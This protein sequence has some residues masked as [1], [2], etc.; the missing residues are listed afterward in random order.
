[1]LLYSQLANIVRTRG[2]E[3]IVSSQITYRT[4]LEQINSRASELCSKIDANAAVA[5]QTNRPIEFIVNF[6]A[7]NKLG[8]AVVPEN[9]EIPDEIKCAHVDFRLIGNVVEAQNRNES[10]KFKDVALIL[11]TSG[12]T[13]M[14][15]AVYLTNRNILS[16]CLTVGQ[17]C[18]KFRDRVCGLLSAP[19][20]YVLGSNMQMNLMLL[21]GG[22]IY[23]PESA[24]IDSMVDALQ[25]GTVNYIC[26]VPLF[27]RKIVDACARRAA[28]F[29]HLEYAFIGGAAWDAELLN[30]TKKYLGIIPSATYGLSETSPIITFSSMEPNNNGD[31]FSVGKSI[32]DVHISISPDNE[33]LVKGPNVAIAAGHPTPVLIGDWLHT[34]DCG[35]LDSQGNLYIT[36]RI[37]ELINKGGIKINCSLI[38]HEI[39][40]FPGVFDCVVGAIRSTKYGE[41]IGVAIYSHGNYLIEDFVF[42]NEHSR[43]KRVLNLDKFPTLKASGKVDRKMIRKMLWSLDSETLTENQN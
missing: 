15:K 21:N 4:L 25:T 26:G 17:T 1:M 6:F 22:S 39:R 36:G 9:P 19:L 27:F 42:L 43:P 28:S 11:F 10:T 16:N 30:D 35:R 24:N 13:G 3:A 41:D 14:P 2:L 23:I 5:V 33:I 37:K 31:A 20:Y 12:S 32:N 8:C 18:F 38:E 29:T 40:K 7:L 34:G